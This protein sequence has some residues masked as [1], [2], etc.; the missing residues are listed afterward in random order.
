[1]MYKVNHLKSKKIGFVGTLVGT[2]LISVPAIAQVMA[3]QPSTKLNPCPRIFYEQP[4]RNRVLVPQ[5][6]PP[7]AFTSR[8]GG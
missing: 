2:L 8:Q 6:C 1:M 7:N 4:H 3:Q 5:G